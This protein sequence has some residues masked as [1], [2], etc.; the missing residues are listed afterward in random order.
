ML[1]LYD[2]EALKRVRYTRYLAGTTA[3]LVRSRRH[4]YEMWHLEAHRNHQLLETYGKLYRDPY[5]YLAHQ[6]R[7]DWPELATLFDKTYEWWTTLHHR[8]LILV[9]ILLQHYR[10]PDLCDK[11]TVLIHYAKSQVRKVLREQVSQD[12]PFESRK[13]E[14][15]IDEIDLVTQIDPRT[16]KSVELWLFA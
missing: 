15:V 11:H 1:K 14:G 2:L 6:L 8:L 12:F 4:K 13:L 7:F 3:S 5:S 9:A 16:G 10:A